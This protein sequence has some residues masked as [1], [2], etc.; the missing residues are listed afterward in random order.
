MRN[1]GFNTDNLVVGRQK[2]LI[3]AFIK[4]ALSAWD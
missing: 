3:T 2:K 4:L 1:S